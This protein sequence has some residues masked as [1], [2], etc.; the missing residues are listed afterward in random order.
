MKFS[1]KNTPDDRA[2]FAVACALLTSGIVYLITTAGRIGI[3]YY[4]PEQHRWSLIPPTGVIAMDW[5]SRSAVTMASALV[6]LA[7]G[8]RFGPRDS[9]RRRSLSHGL[10]TLGL[11]ALAWSFAYTVATLVAAA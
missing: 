1:D 8:A 2:E 3:V 5:F 11:T 6:A 4:L 9:R 10:A 7:L